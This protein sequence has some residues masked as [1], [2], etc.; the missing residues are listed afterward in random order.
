[1]GPNNGEEMKE[2]YTETQVREIYFTKQEVEYVLTEN[3]AHRDALP[4]DFDYSF[5]IFVWRPDGSVQI[6]FVQRGVTKET[7]P[8]NFKWTALSREK[9]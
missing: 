8:H 6:R 5:P 9:A 7:E 1:M 4:Y 3:I 2:R